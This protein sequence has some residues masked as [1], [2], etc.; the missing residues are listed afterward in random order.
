[1]LETAFLLARKMVFLLVRNTLETV[2]LLV[3]NMVF[4]LF[5]NMVFLLVKNISETASFLVRNMDFLLFW[6]MVF[7]FARN[8]SETAFLLDRNMFSWSETWSFSWSETWSFSWSESCQKL[9]LSLGQKHCHS[10][11]WK[12][13]FFP[14]YHAQS[15]APFS[16]NMSRLQWFPVKKL[17][18]VCPN[19]FLKTKN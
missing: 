15:Q 7:L 5:R 3:R 17:Q 18:Y 10:L 9:G 8:I 11:D 14:G 2:F 4:L 19:N 1:M 12:H 6:N 16:S 13:Y